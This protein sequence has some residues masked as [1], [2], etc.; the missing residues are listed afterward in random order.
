[1]YSKNYGQHWSLCVKEAYNAVRQVGAQRWGGRRSRGH[2]LPLAGALGCPGAASP[3][4][5]FPSPLPVAAAGSS[6]G[7]RGTVEARP[8]LAGH[9][10]PHGAL[11]G[12][13]GQEGAGAAPPSRQGCGCA[14]GRR[15]SGCGGG[16]GGAGGPV[17]FS[18]PG[19]GSK[20]GP[21][22]GVAKGRGALPASAPLRPL[23]AAGA[24]PGVC[25]QLGALR[26]G[27]VWGLLAEEFVSCNALGG[28][29]S[30]CFPR[31]GPSNHILH[32]SGVPQGCWKGWSSAVPSARRPPQGGWT[33]V[34]GL[35]A[36]TFVCLLCVV[37]SFCYLL[38]F[39]NCYVLGQFCALFPK[40]RV[41][42]RLLLWLRRL[43]GLWWLLPPL[44][45]LLSEIKACLV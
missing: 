11:R 17:R 9:R 40:F 15:L 12:R 3:P 6:S 18:R 36:Y 24:A 20:G 26:H 22:C 44:A 7:A 32:L 16:S 42:A 41:V 8:P 30:P 28:G 38:L 27:T 37:S 35:C 25:G 4:D 33:I 2:A 43:A 34:G 13:A 45:D 31:R 10:A 39:P 23:L 5:F 14:S 1:M 21:C 19:R 29:H